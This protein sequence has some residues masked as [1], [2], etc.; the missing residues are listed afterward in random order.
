M[1]GLGVDLVKIPRIAEAIERSKDVFL[2]KVFT[3]REIEK[4]SQGDRTAYFATRFAGKEAVL[5]ALC[6]G[7]SHGVRGTEIEIDNGK[8][9]EPVVK[10]SGRVRDIATQKGIEKILLSLSY[11]SDYAVAVAVLE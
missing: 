8:F 2:N 11:D 9:G 3:K 10:L 4:A 5:K 7:W 1:I 6:V